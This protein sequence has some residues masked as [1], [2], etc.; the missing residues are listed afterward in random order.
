M[1][2]TAG[3]DAVSELVV[4]SE[5]VAR[6][7]P[8]RAVVALETTLVAHGFPPGEGVDVGLESEQRVRESGAVP[9]TVGV[10]D[11]RVRVGLARAD[12]GRSRPRPEVRPARHRRRRRAGRGRRDH[13]GGTLAA[14]RSAGIRFLG[15]GGLGG[16]HR[17]F[18]D[19]PA[20]GLGL[21]LGFALVTGDGVGR[22]AAV[23]RD[24]VLPRARCCCWWR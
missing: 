2:R 23:R 22:P 18:P 14:A 7:S 4:V 13:R 11:G 10:I 21:G 15:T 12:L 5:E 8:G 20:A 19:P 16:V 24:D 17:G 1:R 9:A 6:R 3:S